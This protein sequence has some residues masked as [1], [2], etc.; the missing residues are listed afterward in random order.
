[1]RHLARWYEQA[2]LG[3]PVP[4]LVLLAC[5]LGFFSYHTQDFRLDASADSLLL[6]DD[7]DLRAFRM[8]SERYQARNFLVV[9]FIPSQPI[10]AP[11]TLAQISALAAELAALDEVES[12]VSLLDAPLVR[13][14]QGSL[15][16]AV[17]NYKNLTNSDVDLVRA[18]EEL[19]NSPL[20]AELVISRDASTTAL[21]LNLKEHPQLRDLQK[22]KRLLA[23]RV[24][25]GVASTAERA[26]LTQARTAYAM[27][28]AELDA[29]NH[30]T[31][32]EVRSIIA[33]YQQ[34]G[35][36]YLGGVSMIADD[37]IT[38][39]K[40]DLLVF[41]IGVFV[42]LVGMLSIIFR[43]ARWV[44]L[45]LASCF[46]AGLLMIGLLG[47]A[48]WQVT[49]ISSNFISLML[50]L[51]MSMSIHLVVRYRQLCR[52]QPESMHR[53]LVAR[54]VRKMV[55]PC[56]Y[57]ALTTIIAFGSLVVSDIKPVID[58]G[59]MMSVGLAVTFLTSFL[60]FPTLLLVLGR[61]PG[62]TTTGSTLW[63]TAALSR[64]TARHGTA[65][66]V[67]SGL[68]AATGVVG[69]TRLE[70]ENSFVNYFSNDT[71]IYQGLKLVDDK[72]GGTTPLDILLS[73][74]A[75]PPPT[76]NAEEELKGALEE[77]DDLDELLLGSISSGNKDDYW[78]T[79]TRVDRI[80]AVHDYVSDLYGVGQVLSLAS[81]VRV[82]EEI[83]QGEF[84]AFELALVN[85]R[86]PDTLKQ[87]MIAP[88]VS[89]DNNEA[90]ISLRI[91]DSLT[92]LRRNELL[93]NI[94][95]G[96]TS[97]LGLAANSFEVTGLLVLYNNMLQSLFSSQIQTLGVVMLGIALMLMVLFRSVVLA[98]IGIVP[99]LLAAA[100]VLGLMGWGG[101]PLDMMTI[102]IASITLGIAVDNSIHYIYRFRDE[103]A[104]RGDY[105]ATLHYCH[106][107]IGRAIFYTAITI[108]VGFSILVLSNFLPT[109]YFGLLTALAMAIALLAAL[110]LLP[111]LI[112]LLRPFGSAAPVAVNTP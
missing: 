58:F 40:K 3:R 1:M 91:R 78:F 20:F 59:W 103:Y 83:N 35:Q 47:L 42:F 6:E 54:T 100:V 43:A 64:L 11:E 29:R 92:D 105:P 110:T 41:G 74:D 18:K 96:L 30:Q 46:Y 107:N 32:G 56:L 31:I 90:R 99:N 45:P 75:L 77:E 61:S 95:N 66:L 112:L 109:I 34:H 111:K 86:M 97:E 57:T 62:E 14:V 101:I 8:L 63:V 24:R 51:T 70:V 17:S 12:V 50:I 28:K 102:T 69:I 76:D 82:G 88:F 33:R 81:L 15:A 93:Q 25:A 79:P 52:D 98:L 87:T 94:Q 104:R 39:I 9:A 23:G 67:V 22:R 37:M 16:E 19:T 26:Q 89:I 65:V 73:F 44:L 5:V 108:I 80:K 7:E 49:V 48:G 2:I 84:D 38:F 27:L 55:W 21:Q 85:K 36:L 68:L 71:E 72:L 10:F 13:Q 106:A 53:E 4:V 60:L